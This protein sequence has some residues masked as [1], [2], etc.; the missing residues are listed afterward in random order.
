MP[1][2]DRGI[3]PNIISPISCD[4]SILDVLYLSSPKEKQ[5]K[6]VEG[7]GNE[8]TNIRG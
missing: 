4:I 3:A 1:L 8:E 6:T 7:M 5:V 2:Y